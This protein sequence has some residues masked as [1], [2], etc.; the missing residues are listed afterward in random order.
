M[1]SEITYVIVLPDETMKRLEIY[2]TALVCIETSVTAVM[3]A[4]E[5]E[6]G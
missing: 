2:N 4:I 5:N 1:D 6:R 3:V